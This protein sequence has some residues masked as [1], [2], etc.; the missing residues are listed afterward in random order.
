MNAEKQRIKSMLRQIISIY[1]PV[2]SLIANQ[3]QIL[4]NPVERI[5]SNTPYGQKSVRA[6]RLHSIT[7][8]PH[9]IRL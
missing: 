3:R 6:P 7:R 8:S 2:Q 9:F 1:Y 4:L 5:L